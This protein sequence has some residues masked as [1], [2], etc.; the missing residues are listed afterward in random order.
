M[1]GGG[2][3]RQKAKGGGYEWQSAYAR[4]RKDKPRVKHSPFF[5]RAPWNKLLGHG[6]GE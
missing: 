4:Q 6:C 1:N 5:L 3:A 2:S